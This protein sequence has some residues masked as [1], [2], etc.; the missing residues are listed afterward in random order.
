MISELDQTRHILQKTTDELHQSQ[1]ERAKESKALKEV[2]EQTQQ[3]LDDRE[4]VS[5]ATVNSKL[6]AY[7]LSP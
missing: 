2:L 1:L 3:A 4:K 6:D 7:M 5:Y